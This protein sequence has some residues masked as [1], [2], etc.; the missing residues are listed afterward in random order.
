ME[1]HIYLPKMLI[2]TFSNMCMLS[3]LLVD[4]LL[5]DSLSG[6]IL[7]LSK[8]DLLRIALNMQEWRGYL[9]MTKIWVTNY[10]V[11]NLKETTF[12]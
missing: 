10:P 3:R 8:T 4:E 7:Y 5:S 1:F 11:R 9:N 2:F 12:T 6:T